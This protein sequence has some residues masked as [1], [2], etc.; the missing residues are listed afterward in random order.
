M[1]SYNKVIFGFGNYLKGDDAI[2]LEVVHYINDKMDIDNKIKAVDIGNDGMLMLTYFEDD[3]DNILIIDCAMVGLE[4]GNYRIFTPEEVKSKKNLTNI[5][6]HES[7]IIKIIELGK[8]IG[9][10]IPP[11]KLLGIQPV[12]ISYNTGLSDLL[13]N[14]LHHYAEISIQ[15][16]TK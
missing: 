3:L 10:K 15:E 6:T 2:G 1:V 5:S 7:D 8:S 12:S 9:Y 11:I 14:R 13:K 4:P 16:V